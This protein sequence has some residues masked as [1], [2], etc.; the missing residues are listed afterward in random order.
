MMR[1]SQTPLSSAVSAAF[2]AAI[3]ALAVSGAAVAADIPITI[4]AS[5]AAASATA[6]TAEM[7]PLTQVRLQKLVQLN[8]TNG[9]DDVIAA[10]FAVALGLSKGGEKVVGH[11]TI[12]DLGNNKVIF[13]R[14]TGPVEGFNLG[15]VASDGIYVFRVD[16]D[17][18]LVAAAQKMLGA[19]VAPIP[20]EKARR[21]LAV[22]CDLLAK[23]SDHVDFSAA[24][25]QP[26]APLPAAFCPLLCPTLARA[27]PRWRCWP[28]TWR[29]ATAWRSSTACWKCSRTRRRS[30]SLRATTVRCLRGRVAR[31]AA[32][33]AVPRAVAARR[34]APRPPPAR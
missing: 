7:L 1:S 19:E 34:H 14:L 28:G 6:T 2:A 15:L 17:L 27:S 18:N 8:L 5:P 13:S 24:S 16:K 23:I 30:T 31:A 29:Q 9:E 25:S 32:R 4:A 22:V 3:F 26:A 33:R 11:Q 10:P 21:N 20:E 12:F